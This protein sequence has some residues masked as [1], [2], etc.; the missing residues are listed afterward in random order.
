MHKSDHVG[1]PLE[2]IAPLRRVPTH[3]HPK[4]RAPPSPS[5]AERAIPLGVSTLAVAAP[6]LAAKA[7]F[8]LWQTP[9]RH[10]RPG[11]ELEIDGRAKLEWVETPAGR[12]ATYRWEAG[13]DLPWERPPERG[14]VLLVHGWEGRASQLGAMV[15]PLRQAGFTPIGLDAPAHGRS[16]GRTLDLPGFIAAIKAAAQ[17]HGPLAGVVAHSFGGAATT[18]AVGRGLAVPKL[19]LVGTAGRIE[20]GFE[21]FVRGVGL[22]YGG[23]AAFLALLEERYGADLFERYDLAQH[24][25]AATVPALIVHDLD[26]AE[27]PF[28]EA[29]RLLSRWPG[30][31][32]VATAGL[33][34][35]RVLRDRPVIEEIVGF[36]G[37]P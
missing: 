11:R 19:V 33:G 34:H 22:G 8:S 24:N 7:A 30:A 15:D 13:P 31:R 2:P 29:T 27:V 16:S 20:P 18:A 35:R 1:A 12:V 32:L 25:G 37:A 17:H 3:G 28:S 23:R 6:R 26:D 36:L 14:V 10:R 4:R 21:A 9:R 5:L